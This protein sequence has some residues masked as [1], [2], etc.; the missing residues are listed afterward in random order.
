[1]VLHA[2]H[3]Y[4][5]FFCLRFISSPTAK[6]NQLRWKSV[7]ERQTLSVGVLLVSDMP[8]CRVVL[9]PKLDS[10]SLSIVWS[11]LWRIV[12]TSGL[13]EQVWSAAAVN[14]TVVTASRGQH[15]TGTLWL[16]NGCLHLIP[17][18]GGS[19]LL[20][21]TYTHTAF[22][23]NFPKTPHWKPSYTHTFLTPSLSVIH[24]QA[25]SQHAQFRLHSFL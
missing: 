8:L 24:T 13:G 2:T 1:M 3:G 16:K 4:S 15:Y 6:V 17:W 19:V 5:L 23:S 18:T 11:H 7:S 21:L 25:I 12:G 14:T 9:V 22:P 20:S 10:I